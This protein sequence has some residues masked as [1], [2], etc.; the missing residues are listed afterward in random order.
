M[1]ILASMGLTIAEFT[2]D[3]SHLAET[4]ELNLNAL[5]TIAD[6]QTPDY[7]RRM[8]IFRNQFRQVRAYT[9]H[10]GSMLANNAVRELKEID[11][12]EFVRS[13]VE[14]LGVMFHKRGLELKVERPSA[15]DLR[16]VPM[17]ASEWSSILLNLLT[18]SMKAAARAGRAGRF[19]VRLGRSPEGVFLDFSDNGD[20]I[21]DENRAQIFDAF[22]TTG[23]GSAARAPEAVQAVGTGLG[24][25]IVSDIVAAAG[26]TVAVIDPVSGYNTSIRVTVPRS[27][28]PL[29]ANT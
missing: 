10:F 12:Y 17:H 19:L 28:T 1:R 3:F 23:G 9:S 13:F 6:Q 29:E 14:D 25:K 8:D 16:T 27:T 20:G 15:Y 18:N 4:M 22:F 2:H 24:L 11:L 7:Q 26:G 21:P 5:A